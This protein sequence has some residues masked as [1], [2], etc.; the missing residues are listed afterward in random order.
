[1]AEAAEQTSTASAATDP[2]LSVVAPAY[3]EAESLAPLVAELI[4]ICDDLDAYQPYE[5]I[6]VDD[7]STDETPTVLDELAVTHPELRGVHLTR[8][9]GQSAALA[10]GIDHA[11]GATIVTIDADLQNDPAD[12]PRLLRE[13]ER[14][15]DCVSGNRADREDPLRKRIPSRVQTRL[16]KATGPEIN[17]FGCTLKAY[18]ADA[19]A[20]IDLRGE[21]HRYIPAKLYTEGCRIGELDVNHREREYGETKY[22]AGRLLRGSVDLLYHW[23]QSRFGARPMHIFGTLGVLGVGVGGLIGAV[24]VG[25]RL[26]FGTALA[27]RTPRLILV[28]LLVISGLQFL[29]FGVLTEHLSRLHFEGSEPYR[30]ARV[31]E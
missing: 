27:T 9:H 1:M 3:D 6:I 8:N 20:G 17:D 24:S 2:N 7:G 14:G 28:A 31:V 18:D 13:L 23:F 15:Y 19:L 30:V 10:A 4:D 25:Q 21:G 16:A 26:L 29:V 11:D 12:I 22:G 5:I